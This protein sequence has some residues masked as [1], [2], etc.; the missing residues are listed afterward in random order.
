MPLSC[1]AY[2]GKSENIKISD[3]FHFCLVSLLLQ[4]HMAYLA[5]HSLAVELYFSLSV[6]YI[7]AISGTRGSSGFGSVSNEHMERS[8]EIKRKI[9][10]LNIKT[11]KP[12]LND[13]LYSK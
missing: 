13:M 12:T 5:V 10:S 3:A 11:T 8:T 1:A 7:L 6:L 4:C 9:F 2:H